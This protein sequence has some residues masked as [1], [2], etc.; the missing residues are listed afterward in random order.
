[1]IREARYDDIGAIL[2]LGE[3]MHA[4]SRFSEHP[5]SE[6]RVEQL[7][8]SGIDD[9]CT[10]VLVA[11]R[12][13]VM[14]G[15]FCGYVMQHWAVDALTSGDYWLFMGKAHRGGLDAAVMLRRYARWARSKGVPDSLITLGITTQVQVEQSARLFGACG[16]VPA[17]P[18]F[19][20]GS[21]S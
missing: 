21:E 11:E 7:L 8:L 1:M 2:K 3:Q 18:L 16:F 5:W 9:P 15:G 10:L 12:G 20:F 17:G 14:V 13:G 6:G 19:V 4:E